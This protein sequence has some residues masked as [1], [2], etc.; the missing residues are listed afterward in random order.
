MVLKL[1]NTLTRK[2]EIFKPINN[3]EVRI[4][5]C[6]PTVYNYP[7]IGNYRAY[8]FEDILRRYLKYKGYKVKQ[9][10]NITDVD[11]KTIKGSQNENISLKEFTS[12]YEKAFFKE[13]NK[14]N[15]GK[16]EFYPRATEHIKEMVNL[17]KK[18]IDKNYAYESNDGIY[19][20]ISKFKDYGKLAN[21]NKKSLMSGASG[22]VKKDEYDKKDVQDFALWKFWDEEDG[23]VFWETEIGKGRPGW[24][25]ECS[26][27]SMKY[28]GETFDIHAGGVDL[29]FPHHENEI[30]QSVVTGK[31]FVNYWIH[32]EHLLVN[33]QKMSKSL[34]NFYTLHDLINKGYDL[35]AIRYLLLSVRYR[36]K[37]NFTFE[38]LQSAKNTVDKLIDFIDRIKTL[39]TNI[40]DNKNINSLIKKVK[41]KFENSMDDDLN[42]SSALSYLFKFITKINKLISENKVSKSNAKN[43]YDCMLNFDKVLGILEHKKEIL[44]KEILK[45]IKE[46]EIARKSKNYKKAD[47]IR[48]ILKNRDIIL[49]DTKY[50]VRYK[51]IK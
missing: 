35:K 34:G 4:Y 38:A 10:M 8:V 44:S 32:N 39:K 25:I 17:I 9:V 26:A 7:H 30:A 51:N 29:I 18:L 33:N 16:V 45:L 11:D 15:I 43:I 5:T 3:K 41:K 12:R 27:M 36:Q 31:K 13:L 19:Y 23:N 48:E 2:K 22:R 42:I 37:L 14:L 40:K 46:R 6:G 20:K 24:H 50:G 21:I 1:Y 49:E 47:E 28:L